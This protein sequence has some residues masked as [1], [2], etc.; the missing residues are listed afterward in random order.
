MYLSD[1]EVVVVKSMVIVHLIIFQNIFVVG[2]H[3]IISEMRYVCLDFEKILVARLRVAVK[4]F[5]RVKKK[6]K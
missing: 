1:K 6:E 5:F 3:H 4:Y 2:L